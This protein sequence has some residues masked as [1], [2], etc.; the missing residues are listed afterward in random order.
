MGRPIS[1]SLHR[2]ADRDYSYDA[3]AASSHPRAE[4]HTG[5]VGRGRMLL[6]NTKKNLLSLIVSLLSYEL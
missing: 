6:Q 3:T 1:Q 4:R 5:P 2:P